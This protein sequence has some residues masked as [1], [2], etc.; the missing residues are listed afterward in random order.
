VVIRA[1][2]SIRGYSW[3]GRVDSGRVSPSGVH[4]LALGEASIS[5]KYDPSRGRLEDARA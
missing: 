3:W 5:E 2:K 1:T 4:A